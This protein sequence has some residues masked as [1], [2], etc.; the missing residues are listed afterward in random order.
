MTATA[1]TAERRRRTAPGAA[2]DSVPRGLWIGFGFCLI[3][4]KMNEF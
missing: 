2:M 3:A 4:K 1:E